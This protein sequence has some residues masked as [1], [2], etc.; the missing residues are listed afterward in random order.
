MCLSL[1]VTHILI[2][3]GILCC[4]YCIC[5]YRL[6]YIYCVHTIVHMHSLYTNSLTI[7][8]ILY[9]IHIGLRDQAIL[10]FERAVGCGDQEGIA[11]RDLARL[12][13]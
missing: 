3:Y 13:R 11:T 9:N 12:C 6:H 10:S 2:L 4:I 5:M 1:C 8:Y 7:H